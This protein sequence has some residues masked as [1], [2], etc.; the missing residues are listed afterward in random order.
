MGIE[1]TD[2]SEVHVL[3]VRGIDEA[4]SLAGRTFVT[5][6]FRMD[7]DRAK[8]FERGTYLTDYPHPYGGEDAYGEGLVEG[9]HLLGML[10]FLINHGLYCTDSNWIAWN[11]GL[12]HAR[13]VTV[14]RDS[15]SY[16]IR[17]TVQEVIDRGDQGHLLVLDLVGEVR[18]RQKPGFVAT[19]RVL[20]TLA[21]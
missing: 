12:D 6:W 2:P 8:D 1:T 15:D 5:P 16:R 13:F 19:L 11:Y 14:I 21:R 4:P 9:F 3:E 17:G 10:D 7:Q 18:G 20:W